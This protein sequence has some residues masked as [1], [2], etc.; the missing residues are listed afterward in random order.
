MII[1]DWLGCA[2]FSTVHSGAFGAFFVALMVFPPDKVASNNPLYSWC[3][4]TAKNLL[5]SC[6]FLRLYHLVYDNC[7][8]PPITVSDCFLALGFTWVGLF[9]E[10]NP[11]AL[12][13]FLECCLPF[14]GRVF[15]DVLPF[16]AFVFFSAG[17]RGYH[18]HMHIFGR[19]SLA[20]A[21]NSLPGGIL[22]QRRHV[23]ATLGLHL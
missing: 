22:K 16:W 12:N 21:V 1:V 17:A 3:S 10:T 4:P 6:R 2:V 14:I 9:G 8:S 11:S 5:P 7:I 23:A 18:L 19:S 13:F 20:A 15:F